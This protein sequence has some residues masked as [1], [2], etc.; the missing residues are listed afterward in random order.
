MGK[1][2]PETGGYHICLVHILL[3]S[4]KKLAANIW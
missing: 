4:P 3:H 2:R 1:S